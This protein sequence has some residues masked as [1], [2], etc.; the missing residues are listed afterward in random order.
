[1]RLLILVF[2]PFLFFSCASQQKPAKALFL[3][4]GC[5]HDFKKQTELI[6]Q[7]SPTGIEWTV[8]HEDKDSNKN[9]TKALS[10]YTDVDLSSYD[11]IIHNECLGKVIDPDLINKVYS[12]H[13]KSDA[14]IIFIHCALHTF[15]YAKKN[16]ATWHKLMG[17]KSF[18]HEHQSNY[19]VENLQPEHPVMEGFPKVWQTPKDELYIIEK[20]FDTLLPLGRSYSEK[21]NKSHTTIWV[22]KLDDKR[23]FGTSFGHKT[24]T[25]EDP[26]F[27]KLLRNAMLWS[28]G[29]K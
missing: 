1:M 7:I 20:E 27:Q 3:T 28:L 23:I 5:C 11:L 21:D 14:G 22:N 13:L 19:I 6:K 16:A 12:E 8:I 4:G 29:K 18:T 26:V 17:L 2:L 15:R 9:S 25:F 10:L 24:E